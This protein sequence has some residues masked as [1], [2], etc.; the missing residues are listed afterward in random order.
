MGLGLPVDP[1]V[2]ESRAVVFPR[3]DVIGISLGIEF[4]IFLL[5]ECENKVH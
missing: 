3:T 4:K 1:V 2:K 5:Y